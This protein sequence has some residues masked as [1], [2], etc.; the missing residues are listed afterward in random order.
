MSDDSIK[1]ELKSTRIGRN[2]QG[3]FWCG[4]CVKIIALEK[5][6]LEAWDERFNHVDDKHFK[7]GQP[8]S[9]W[10][11]IDGH[12]P[13]GPQSEDTGRERISACEQDETDDETG[14]AEPCQESLASI[15]A[16]DVLLS[17]RKAT[18]VT[19]QAQ[20]SKKVR[21]EKS[22]SEKQTN[23]YCVSCCQDRLGVPYADPITND[24][25][26]VQLWTSH[27]RVQVLYTV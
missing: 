9:D 21:T 25:V 4:F 13:K 7:R 8:I 6:G 3:Q 12:G 2:G 15:L 27:H 23:R 11:P 10:V 17:K 14:K 26:Y 20:P 19:A 1:E 5:K 16:D 22:R 18:P 24:I